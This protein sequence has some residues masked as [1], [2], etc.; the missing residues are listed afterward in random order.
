[1]QPGATRQEQPST[2]FRVIVVPLVQNA[3][4]DY[5]ICKMADD[6]GVFPGQWGLPGGG[7]EA[8][9]RM[10]DALR[11]EVREEL[12]I[13]VNDIKPLFFKDGQYRKSFADGTQADVYMIFLLFTCRAVTNELKL[14][15]EFSDYAWVP[16]HSLRDY[17]LNSTTIETF[18]E[19]G[20]LQS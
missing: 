3:D 16:H 2:Q 8:G 20:I 13:E 4:G 18:R 19:A 6:R 12:G 7:I 17:D 15:P 9:E 5:L 14:N 11:R 1:M 10:I